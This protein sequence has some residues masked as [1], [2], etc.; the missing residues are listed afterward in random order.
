MHEDINKICEFCKIKFIVDFKHRKQ[1]FCSKRCMYD[2]RKE[3]NWEELK[4]L[5]CGNKF[6]SRKKDRNF[7]S[8]KKRMFCS[9][10]CN[11]SS[12]YRKKK[13][14]EFVVGNKNPFCRNDVKEK[15]K[16]TKFKEYGDENYNNPKKQKQTVY[17]RYG[18][19]CAFFRKSNGKRITSIQKTVFNYIKHRYKS[20]K[21]EE[22]LS[23]V[24]I[25]VDIYIPD[26]KVVIETDGDY[27]HM[28]PNKYKEDD[29]NKSTHKTAK[30]TWEYDKKRTEILRDAGYKVISIWETDIKNGNYFKILNEN[31]I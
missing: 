3:Q 5:E 7:V 22:T 6:K 30:E 18:T 27:W 23:D 19:N 25:S 28:N 15:I 8:G 10:E 31:N 24:L 26:K 21:I 11:R 14:S 1:R 13:L 20:A 4:C 29:Y 2:W 12:Q 16:Q 17:D 9:Q